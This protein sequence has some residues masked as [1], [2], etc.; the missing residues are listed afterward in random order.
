LTGIPPQGTIDAIAMQRAALALAVFL[1]RHPILFIVMVVALIAGAVPG[2]TSI[3]TST[4]FD[5]F[6]G[7]DTW[8][9]RDYERYKQVFGDEPILI[10]IKGDVEYIVSRQNLQLMV[11]LEKELDSDPRFIGMMSPATYLAPLLAYPPEQY[12]AALMG[13][14][15][16]SEGSIN[17]QLSGVI[18]KPGNVLI[19]LTPAGGT[20]QEEIIHVQQEVEERMALIVT[21]GMETFVSSDAEVLEAL[22]QEIGQSLAILLGLAIVIMVVLLV[23]LFRVRWR[24]LSLI[25]VLVA[26]LWTFGLMG[27]AGISLSMATMAVVPILIGLG[28]D[29]SLQFHSRYQ[30]ELRRESSVPAAIIRSMAAISPGVGVAFGATAV[31]FLTLLMSRVPMVKDFGIVLTLGIFLSYLTA[32]FF[33]N[34]I[35]ALR[36]RK[37]R[38]EDLKAESTEASHREE[39]VLGAIARRLVGHPIPILI[40]AVGVFLAGAVLDHRLDVVTEWERLMP[41]DITALEELREVRKVVG[42]SGEL[43]FMVEGEDVLQPEVVRWM[44]DYA[45]QQRE[46]HPELKAVASPAAVVSGY[47]GGT[48]PDSEAEIRSILD[49][50]PNVV[51][52][53]VVNDAGTVAVITFPMQQLPLKEVGDVLESMEADLQPPAVVTVSATGNFVMGTEIMDAIV[54]ARLPMILAGVGGVFLGLFLIYRRWQRV[55]FALI[56]MALVIGWSSLAMF[57]FD[58]AINPLTAIMSAIIVGIGTEFAVLLL[59]RYHEEK[60]AGSG[61]RQAMVTACSSLGRAIVTS[62][63]TTLGGFA[64]LVGS[65]FVMIQDFGRVTVIDV[66]L[67]LVSVMIVLPPLVVWFDEW[68]LRKASSRRS[69][70]GTSVTEDDAAML[71]GDDEA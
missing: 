43:H 17:P 28:I 3:R 22:S 47:T 46:L 1:Q 39:R 42:Y 52:Q 31:G 58:I 36:D 49:S 37:A 5:M 30:E 53:M 57:A 62:A 15:Y 66:A 7:R 18:P 44:Q 8:T 23:L 54:G 67:C 33:L 64:C 60:E 68:R 10:L 12:Y 21:P 9:Y 16:T 63:L 29:Y 59:E 38:L 70:S 35:L 24:L 32:L 4:D 55:V 11:E 48:I 71:V 69:D 14:L 25:M 65:D 13:V 50:V 61:P 34:S 20:S 27:Y 51:R 26:C 19:H 40:V 2:V 41:Q 56:P 45:E 6:V